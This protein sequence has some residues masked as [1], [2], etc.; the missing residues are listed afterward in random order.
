MENF[1]FL[2]FLVIW[3]Q[4]LIP[5]NKASKALQQQEIDI[6][7][8]TH[9]LSMAY[10]ELQNLRYSRDSLVLILSNCCAMESRCK[11]QPKIKMLKM[12]LDIAY[13]Y[14]LLTQK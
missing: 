10:G 12:Y 11:W 14:R 7:V 1:K 2:L 13:F 4:I 5:M 8:S 9:L 6:L 3:E